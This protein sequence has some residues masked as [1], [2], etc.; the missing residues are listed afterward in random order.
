[1]ADR[2]AGPT[3][4]ARARL[5]DWPFVRGLSATLPSGPDQ[6]RAILGLAR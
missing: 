3:V 5:A 4:A 2:P 1:M 6:S